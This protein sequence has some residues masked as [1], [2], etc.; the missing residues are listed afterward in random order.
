MRT[1]DEQAN[2]HTTS[3]TS[4]QPSAVLEVDNLCVHFG[5]V[6]AVDE[7]S[8]SVERGCLF[9]VLGP[10]GSGKSTLLAAVSRLLK[11]TAGRVILNGEDVTRLPTYR[12]AGRGMSRTF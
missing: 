11:P 3:T 1:A 12:L 7:V 10:N 6:K 2:S 5:G 9:G 8:F 4:T